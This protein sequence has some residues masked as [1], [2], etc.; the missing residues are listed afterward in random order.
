MVKITYN[1][2]N[3]KDVEFVEDYF[4]LKY[5]FKVIESDI[6][7]NEKLDD[8]IMSNLC[9]R[10]NEELKKIILSF[11]RESDLI[12]MAEILNKYNYTNKNYI[13]W[14]SGLAIFGTKYYI[15]VFKRL[16][17]YKFSTSKQYKKIRV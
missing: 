3:K 14:L 12:K 2:N 9:G 10:L 8:L 6:L 5:Q 4:W 1:L 13:E 16:L 7:S 11:C 15:K 17:I